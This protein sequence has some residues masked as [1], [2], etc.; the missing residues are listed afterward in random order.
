MIEAMFYYALQ[1]LI[2]GFAF[3]FAFRIVFR[4]KF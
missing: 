3:A 1:S 4:G 2:M